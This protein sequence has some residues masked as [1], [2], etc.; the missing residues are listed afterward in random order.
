VLASPGPVLVDF[1]APWCKPCERI[2]PLV[3]DLAAR[4]AGRVTLGALDVEANPRSA[5]RY[6]VLTLPTLILFRDGDPVQRVTGAVNADK[7]E[8]AMSPHLT[9]G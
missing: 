3:R 6:D 1:W 4:H 8:R 9:S 5:A 2:K 7:L